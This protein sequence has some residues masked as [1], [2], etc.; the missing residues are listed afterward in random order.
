MRVS[1]ANRLQAINTRPS[2][3]ERGGPHQRLL[4]L[5]AVHLAEADQ[6]GRLL[7][8]GRPV[9]EWLDFNYYK[10]IKA[11]KPGYNRAFFTA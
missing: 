4:I 2:R 11:K 1:A 3:D 6:G 7:W 10:L 8:A 9:T 5:Q